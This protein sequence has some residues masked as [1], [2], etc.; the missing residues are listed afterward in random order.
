MFKKLTA[1]RKKKSS[2]KNAKGKAVSDPPPLSFSKHCSKDGD[3]SNH[4]EQ[5][6][7]K[8]DQVLTVRNILSNAQVEYHNASSIQSTNCETLVPPLYHPSSSSTTFL[9]ESSSFSTE[10][11]SY[12]GSNRT[13]IKTSP[14]LPPPVAQGNLPPCQPTLASNE[15]TRLPKLK[16]LHWDKVRAAPDRSMVWD[17]LKSSSFEFDE[18]LI[19]SLFSYN[20]QNTNEELKTKSP[21]LGK[22]VLE[23]K[24]LQN[25]TILLKALNATTEQVCCALVQG[26]GL[27]LQQLEILIKMEPTKEEEAKITNFKGDLGSAE[28]FVATILRIPYAFQRIQALLYKETFEDEVTHIRTTFSLLEEACKELRSS[29]L[30]LKLL[31]AVLKMGNRMNVGTIR[32]GAKAFKLNALLKLA[33]IKGTDEKTTLLHFVVQGIVHSEGVRASESIIGMINQKNNRRNIQDREDEYRNMGLELVGGLSTELCNVKKTATIDYMVIASSVSNLSQGLGRL[34]TLVN[35][36]LNLG[37]SI[38]SFFKYAVTQLKELK[39]HEHKVF[40]LVK[41]ITEYF[42][43]SMSKDEENPLR[44]FVIVRDFLAMLDRVCR[45]LRRSKGFTHQ[46]LVGSFQ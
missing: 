40:E 38:K 42:H 32:G 21:Y 39:D 7:A 11:D 28:T 15:G 26:S 18:E 41:Q 8:H 44:I 22:P 10:S 14:P 37:E 4:L 5:D 3:R 16:P 33:D 19:E 31:E 2:L 1:H 30:F 12:S 36:D 27:N 17:Q 29:R 6:D 46:N 20:Q 35:Q 13:H 34:R 9:L 43:G 25:L 23:P 45:E 24:R